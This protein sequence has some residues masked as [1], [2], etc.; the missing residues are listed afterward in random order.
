MLRDSKEKTCRTWRQI[1]RGK[2]KP[3]GPKEASRK[4]QWDSE[5][6][7]WSVEKRLGTRGETFDWEKEKTGKTSIE[8]IRAI[9]NCRRKK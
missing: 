4:T 9:I 6:R 5:K 1:L 2:T 7:M 3:N 8:R